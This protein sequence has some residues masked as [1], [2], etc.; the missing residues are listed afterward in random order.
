MRKAILLDGECNIER[1]WKYTVLRHMITAQAQTG[2]RAHLSKESAV[3]L[4]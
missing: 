3:R 2:L 1:F 4:F